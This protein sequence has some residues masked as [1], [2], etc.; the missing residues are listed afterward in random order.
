MK[1]IFFD[2]FILQQFFQRIC[3]SFLDHHSSYTCGYQYNEDDH[4]YQDNDNDD[5]KN[6]DDKNDDDEKQKQNA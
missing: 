4:H 6:D 3:G 1:D 5:D 2:R